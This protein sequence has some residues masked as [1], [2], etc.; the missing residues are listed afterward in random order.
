[1]ISTRDGV[2][3]E[4][5]HLKP[6]KPVAVNAT[7]LFT[8]LDVMLW[9]S[10]KTVN[11]INNDGGLQSGITTYLSL[12]FELQIPDLSTRVGLSEAAQ[13]NLCNMV[14]M[15]LFMFHSL[16]MG[17]DTHLGA[18]T[19]E[20]SETPQ[21]GLGDAFYVPAT[22]AYESTR[23]TP[24]P[25]TI[26]GYASVG[27]FLLLAVLLGQLWAMSYPESE[28]SAYPLLDLRTKLKIINSTAVDASTPTEEQIQIS[29]PDTSS[30]GQILHAA[31]GLV[32]MPRAVVP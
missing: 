19:F 24:A 15:P 16:L 4:L 32:V 3:R 31:G 28:T 14:L 13:Q 23:P 20:G 26:Y 27:G 29:F 30:T 10:S 8:A 22:Y 12:N 9:P 18:A 17:E 25:W 1:M 6:P 21:P 7:D 5:R 2:I 11:L